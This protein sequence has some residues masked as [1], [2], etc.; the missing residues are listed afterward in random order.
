MAFIL[1]AAAGGSRPDYVRQFLGGGEFCRVE[2]AAA[3]GREDGEHGAGD[4]AYAA[5]TRF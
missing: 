1:A 2:S 4:F 3:R 5:A